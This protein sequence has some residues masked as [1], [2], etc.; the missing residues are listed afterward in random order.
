ML[1]CQQSKQIT[2]HDCNIKFKWLKFLNCCQLATHHSD[3][4]MCPMTSQSPATRLLAELLLQ[5]Q[6]RENIKAPR[7]WPLWGELTSGRWTPRTK[8]QW[9]GNCFHL[10]TSSWIQTYMNSASIRLTGRINWSFSQLSHFSQQQWRIYAC[11][12]GGWGWSG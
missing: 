1:Y 5:A 2:N 4:I 7:Y 3:V 6:K 8:G 12:C 10:K 11:V 9:R